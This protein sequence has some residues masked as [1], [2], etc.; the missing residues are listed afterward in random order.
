MPGLNLGESLHS[1]VVLELGSL[2]S[3]RT[4]AIAHLSQRDLQNLTPAQR[5]EML[6]GMQC[7]AWDDDPGWKALTSS[8]QAELEGVDCEILEPGDRRYDPALLLPL[9]HRYLGCTNEYLLEQ[10]KQIDHHYDQIS[11]E[12]ALLFACPC[13]GLQTLDEQGNYDICP[14]CWWEDDGMDNA[15][16]Q[17]KSGPNHISL[18]RA[19]INVLQTG[20]FDP[21]RADLRA[22]QAPVEK[23]AR[24]RIFVLGA[25][26]TVVQE[27]AAGWQ[28]CWADEV[29]DD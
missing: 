4:Q 22:K 2:L 6:A 10:L 25:E 16:A 12:A 1:V 13:C 9:R 23:Y 5:S 26:S 3:S 24:A 11:G 18:I 17:Y 15:T 14:V 8:L 19:R 7:E 21:R 29:D 28:G 27:P 20:I